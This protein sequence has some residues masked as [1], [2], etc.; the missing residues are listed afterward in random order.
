MGVAV[1]RVCVCVC[2]LPIYSG[3]QPCGS[4]SGGYTGGRSHMISLPPSFRDAYLNFSREKDSAVPFLRRP[5]KSD[6]VYYNCNDLFSFLFFSFL[7]GKIPV[8]GIRTRVPTCQI[9]SR[10]PSTN[11]ATGALFE[12]GANGG[13]LRGFRRV[14]IFLLKCVE[15]P[16]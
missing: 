4:I 1:D 13:M 11:G 14:Q 3:R 6:F 16:T 2:F 9:V 15:C 5:C 8:S 10:L 12:S 7:S